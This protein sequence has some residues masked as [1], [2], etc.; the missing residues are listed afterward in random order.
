MMAKSIISC[1]PYYEAI[2]DAMTKAM[3]QEFRTNAK[4]SCSLYGD[5]NTSEKIAEHILDFLAKGNKETKKHFYD[6]KRGF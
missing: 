4:Q 6:I 1:A 5:G 2:C 3:T